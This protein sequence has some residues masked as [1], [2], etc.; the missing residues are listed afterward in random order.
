ML[1]STG[2]SGHQ[3][4]LQAGNDLTVDAP[5]MRLRGLL[6]A[7]IELVRDVFESNSYRHTSM[8][9]NH[10]GSNMV[11]PLVQR[12]QAPGSGRLLAQWLCIAAKGVSIEDI[13]SMAVEVFKRRKIELLLTNHQHMTLGRSND[14]H[15]EVKECLLLVK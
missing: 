10:F 2:P 5:V 6:Q 9:R 8:P 4:P 15:R 3:H 7:D 14:R 1:F 11:C 13:E 12:W